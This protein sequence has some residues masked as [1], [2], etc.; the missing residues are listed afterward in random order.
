MNK[1]VALIIFLPL[2]AVAQNIKYNNTADKLKNYFVRVHGQDSI[3]YQRLFFASFPDNFTD[4]NGIFGDD[5]RENDTKFHG[6][7][8]YD[9]YEYISFFFDLKTIP[10]KD[11]YKKIINIAIGG[12]WDADAVNY[13]QHGLHRKV[14][15]NTKLTFDLLK[16][17]RDNEIKSF[18][19]F[20]FT[21]SILLIN[22]SPLNC[23]Q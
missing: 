13:F 4:L 19:F 8:L 20:F 11:F 14:L 5:T 15:Q 10:K 7:P 17:K 9:G 23:R 1:T 2:F 16:V 21:V 3:K 18:F 22:V 12:H 6:A